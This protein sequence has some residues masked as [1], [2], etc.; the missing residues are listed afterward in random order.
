M[1]K[2]PLACALAAILFSQSVQAFEVQDIRVEG[3]QRVSAGR[4][5]NALGLELGDTLDRAAQQ[6]ALRDLFRT[7]LFRDIRLGR[8]GDVLVVDV[9][10]RPSISKIEI[11]GNK[12]I[13]TDQLMKGLKSS[14]LEEGRVFQQ[15]TLEQIE[16][17]LLKSYIEQGRYSAKVEAHTESQPGN[18][19]R[20]EIDIK[21]GP[22][23]AIHH[24]NFIG[25]Q[26]VGDEKL[27][28]LMELEE[29]GFWANVFNSDKYSRQKLGGD[30]ETI[31]SWYLDHGYIQA[32]VDSTEVS[33]SPD[34]EQVYITVDLTEGP[35]YTIADVQLKGELILP[36]EELKSLIRLQPGDVY[37]QKQ[38]NFYADL[39]G[40]KLGAE[41]YTFATVNAIPTPHDDHTAT[42]TYY[43]DPGKRTYV[44]RINFTGNVST[45]DEVL[46]QQM[47]QMESAPAN[48]ELIEASKTRL[49]RLGYFKTVS[50]NTPLVPGHDDLIDVNYAVEEQPTG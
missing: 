11:K 8:D 14:G 27:L 33:I 39:I 25:N 6:R 10:E 19:V 13:E 42:V 35:Q 12:N 50:V 40:K 4:V 36:E 23:A 37:N 48:S 7:G 26:K 18:R 21:E 2:H 32:S 5:I 1:T 15:S 34:R 24:I 47:L 22:V 28:D 30:L 31:R 41:G 16:L 38:V 46:R 44:R 29:T 43:V 9:R 3:L 45:A 17:E 20:I 49:D